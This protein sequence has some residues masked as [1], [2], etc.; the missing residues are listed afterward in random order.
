MSIR[1]DGKVALITG[2][3]RGIGRAIVRALAK[4]G[5][6]VGV[7]Y[8]LNE[9]AALEAVEEARS[10]GVKAV[11][12]QGDVSRSD[13][14]D[15]I[16]EQLV[17]KLGAPDIVISNAA[18]GVLQPALT[19][20]QRQWQ[21][22]MDTNAWSFIALAQKA[23]PYMEGRG[24]KLVAISSLGSVRAIP[25]YTAVGASKA[26]L[27]SI[28][29]HLAAE[30]GPKGINVNCV[31]AGVIDTDALKA[32]PHRQEILANTAGRQPLTETLRPEHVADVVLFLCS[33]LA[34]MVHGHVL[35]VD[36][37]YSIIA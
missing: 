24:G 35:T 17:D 14:I 13:S 26:A 23:V 18:T 1:L 30:L 10:F 6:H 3:S 2:G 34:R 15:E 21:K 16:F 33:D 29:R 7:N 37:G 12:L 9:P 8:F 32:F 25:D 22:V 20:K 28:V 5:A 36:G 4:A 31:S 11:T 19:L 27:E